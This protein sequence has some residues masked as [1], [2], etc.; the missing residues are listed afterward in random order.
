[1]AKGG[2]LLNLFMSTLE[3]VAPFFLLIA[4][5]GAIRK[6][7]VLSQEGIAHI[8]RVN[9]RFFLP[10]MLFANIY[11]GSLFE[12]APFGFIAY[13]AAALLFQY[14]AVLLCAKSAFKAPQRAMAFAVAAFR[15]N[16]A[17]YGLPL[18]MG[19]LGDSGK[20]SQALVLQAG[21]IALS[22]ALAIACCQAFS[23]QGAK[24]FGKA[25]LGAI[26]NPIVLSILAGLAVQPLSFRLP[27]AMESSLS[28]LAS[29]A[30][31]L[32]LVT[33]GASF[34]IGSAYANRRAVAVAA[35][36]KIAAFPL[37]IMLLGAFA[38]GYRDVELTALLCAFATPTAVSAQPLIAEYGGDSALSSDIIVFTT[39]ISVGT[40][41]L[42]VYFFRLAGL[43]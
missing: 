34:R 42:F 33:L 5:G 23:A 29:V 18:A 17:L 26:M 30:T 15:S 37:A 4:A 11:K 12:N 14:A 31:P 9:M 38:F 6:A 35:T 10:C 41:F 20:A 43:F 25:A 32:A 7:G 27:A 36:L 3:I 40:V 19:I 28:S 24:N 22:N 2:L 39:A 13:S 8:N 16:S 1:M 21:S